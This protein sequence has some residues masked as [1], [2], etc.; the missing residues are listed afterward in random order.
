MG[1]PSIM[2]YLQQVLGIAPGGTT[3]DGLFTL[4]TVPCL[5]LCDEAPAIIIDT[6]NHTRLTPEKI[7]KIIDELRKAN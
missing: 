3:D 2:E 6:T 5:G 4:L 1:Y 7:D